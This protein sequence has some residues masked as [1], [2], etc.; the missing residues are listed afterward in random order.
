MDK[1]KELSDKEIA[2][3]LTKLV[4][5]KPVVKQATDETKA[6]QIAT[7]YNTIFKSISTSKNQ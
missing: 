5:I 6:L 3:E 1:S 2:L 4:K 7:V